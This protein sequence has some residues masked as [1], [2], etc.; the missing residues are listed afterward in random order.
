MKMKQY[1]LIDRKAISEKA[2]KLY[3][4]G[5]KGD[6]NDLIIQYPQYEENIILNLTI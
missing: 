1:E 4:T 6:L 3:K 2:I 5:N